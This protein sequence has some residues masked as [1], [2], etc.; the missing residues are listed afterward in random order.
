[1]DRDAGPRLLAI[2]D[3]PNSADLVARVATR[4]GWDAQAA[5]DMKTARHLLSEWR[6]TV[7]TLDLCM[8]ESDGID[9]MGILQQQNFTGEVVIISGQEEWMRKSACRLAEA[10]GL[11]IAGEM[12][13][14]IDVAALQG[15][16]ERLRPVA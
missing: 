1:M 3:S 4:C 7:L 14:P 15:M 6:P 2:D 10:R 13:K 9:V 12:Q 5:V 8:P 11:K 16:L